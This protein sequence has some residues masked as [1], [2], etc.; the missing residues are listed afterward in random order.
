MRKKMLSDFRT[1]IGC[2]KDKVS[3]Q[4]LSPIFTG[5]LKRIIH[6]EKRD[7]RQRIIVARVSVYHQSMK[8]T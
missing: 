8:V 2:F 6:F 3:F 4:H 1:E 5:Y 7:R